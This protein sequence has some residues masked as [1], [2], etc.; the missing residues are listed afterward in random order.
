MTNKEKLGALGEELVA[1]LLNGNLSEN[2][3]DTVKDMIALGKNIE[4]K[5]QNRHPNGTFTINA[6]HTTNVE[7]CMKVDRLIFVEYD[8]TDDIKIFEC[9]DR[10]DYKVITTKATKFEPMGR[11]MI[12][13]PIHK[14]NMLFK[15]NNSTLANQMRQL[16]G[17]RLFNA[18]S[19]Y[20]PSQFI[21]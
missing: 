2:K 19:K 17:S 8:C 14:M 15:I 10:E 4:V 7:K 3:Y 6:Q 9:T 16:S 21:A 5:T 13:W 12:G 11:I 20:Q 1:K 18:N